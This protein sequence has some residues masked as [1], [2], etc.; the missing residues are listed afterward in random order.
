ML[1]VPL[2]LPS[3]T[4]AIAPQANVVVH[5][6]L[7]ADLV[8]FASATFG[9][10][11]DSTFIH[12]VA[13]GFLEPFWNNRLTA[14]MVRQNPPHSLS[15]SMGHL[16]RTRLGQHST[17]RTFAP[18]IPSL[19]TPPLDG[20]Q[21]IEIPADMLYTWIEPSATICHGDL[22]GRMPTQSFAGNNYL[23]ITVLD[24][25]IHMEPLK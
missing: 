4:T 24:G 2:Y 22:T 9:N 5:N 18:P 10:P 17:K 12:A 19:S 6:Q 13:R 21:D 1:R 3:A 15:T 14:R 20:I 8:Y 11:T 16:D 7:N 23:L 25:Y